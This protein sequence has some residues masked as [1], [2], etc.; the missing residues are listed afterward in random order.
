MANTKYVN[1]KSEILTTK[2]STTKTTLTQFSE[3]DSAAP[4]MN[5]KKKS[6]KENSNKK[7]GLFYYFDIKTNFS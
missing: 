6:Q 5:F 2:K 4:V 1:P 3:Q 7:I